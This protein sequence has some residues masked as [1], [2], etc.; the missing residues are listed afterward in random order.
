MRG[1]LAACALLAGCAAAPAPLAVRTP[2]P[3]INQVLEGP[4]A[5]APGHTLIV[6]DLNLAPGAP[7]PRH[8]HHGEEFIYVLGGSSVLSRAGE[9]DLPLAAGQ[10]IRIAPGTVHWGRAG[11]DG[12]RAISSWVKVDGKPLREAAPE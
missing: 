8:W 7:I 12:M 11:P 3:G 9:P 2:P 5:A 4:I 6:G 1:A 10:A